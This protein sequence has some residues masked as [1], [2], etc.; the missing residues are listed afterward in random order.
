MHERVIT[1]VKVPQQLLKVYYLYV[2]MCHY[3][4]THKEAMNRD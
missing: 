4:K 2:I 1:F 3:A